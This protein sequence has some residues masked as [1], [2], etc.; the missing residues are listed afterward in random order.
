MRIA[1]VAPTLEILGGQ[2]VQARA[3]M[4]G[5]R[6]DGNDVLFVPVNPGFPPGLRWL[7]RARYVRT[8]V[9]QARYLPS[10]LRLRRAD[11]VHVFSAS[12]W[13]FVLAPLPAML[14]GRA[15]GKRVVLNY[16]SGEAADHLARWGLLVHPWLRL[17][18]EIVVPSEYL[19]EVFARH[20]YRTHVIRNVVDTSRFHYR[21]RPPLRPQFLSTRNLDRYYRV[22]NTLEAFARVKARRPDA[23]L[24][25][26]GYGPEEDRLR[27]LAASL[28]VA[29]IRFTG[30]VEPADMP[31]L[32]DGADIFLNSSVVDNQP[33]SV[34]EAFAAGLPVVS[35]A[36][37]DLA[38]LVRDG[39][40]GLVV[41]PG[42]PGAMADAAMTL[43]DTPG[44]ASALA[45]RARQEAE[46]YTW[47][48]V[49]QEWAAVYA[50]GGARQA[51][52][53][54]RP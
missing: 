12:Y 48:H 43:L 24:T 44:R 15:F 54:L 50:G 41:P 22:D 25:V 8:V 30:R 5:L 47:A 27:R 9:N 35:T 14:A 51:V 16:H 42:D 4:D 23:T 2:A 38:A 6:G 18:H 32:Y 37:G 40:T 29:G 46:R 31:R 34:L 10:L 3:L 45:R 53:A 49:R 21:E 7:R 33:V 17:P 11:L 13:S 20:G 36:V 28:G 1:V 39:E 19:R 26:A 52:G